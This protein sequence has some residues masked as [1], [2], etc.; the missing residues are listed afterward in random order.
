MTFN[1]FDMQKTMFAEF[2]KGLG[3]YL[4][5][6][7]RDPAFMKVVSQ[8]MAA[9][10]DVRGQVKEQLESIL[11]GLDVPTQSTLEGLYQTVHNLETRLL[12]L[13]ETV[14]EQADLIE[15]LRREP[16]PG[17]TAS[18]PAKALTKKA[19]AKKA[20]TKKAPARGRAR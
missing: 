2:E 11:K 3:Q 4:E 10:L 18:A 9:Q 5:K 13:E 12:D 6:T 8:S 19:P 17:P 1:P 20:A 15:S 14:E 7:M 16:T